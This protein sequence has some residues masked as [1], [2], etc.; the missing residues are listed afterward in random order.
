[1]HKKNKIKINSLVKRKVVV[2]GDE[3]CGKSSLISV[4]TKD[5]FP[6]NHESTCFDTSNETSIEIITKKM[7][8]IG[9]GQVALPVKRNQVVRYIFKKF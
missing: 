7:F 9:L 4:F 5:Y 8:N 2:V 3:N 1:M 6:E